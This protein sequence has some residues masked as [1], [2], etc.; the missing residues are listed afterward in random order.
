M[1]IRKAFYQ[2]LKLRR[3][4]SY[5]SGLCFH[6]SLFTFHPN[7]FHFSKLS[8]ESR[9]KRDLT[10]QIR[11]SIFKFQISDSEFSTKNIFHQRI[12]FTKIIFSPDFFFTKTETFFTKNFF[13]SKKFFLRKFRKCRFFQLPSVGRSVGQSV[14]W[15]VGQSGVTLL[16]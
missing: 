3:S 15:S 11:I 14:G 5:F 9:G 1:G 10:I 2:H 12:F 7:R 13:F 4:F 16:F 8:G 6:F